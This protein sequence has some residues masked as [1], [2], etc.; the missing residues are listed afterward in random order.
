MHIL[1]NKEGQSLVLFCLCLKR[2]DTL[3]FIIKIIKMSCFAAPTG[4]AQHLIA[5]QALTFRRPGKQMN[6]HNQKKKY[7][8]HTHKH[9]FITPEIHYFPFL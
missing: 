4:K 3:F 5:F 6:N 7:M 2:C 8:S 9:T 1:V